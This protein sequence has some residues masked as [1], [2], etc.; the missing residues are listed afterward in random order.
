GGRPL[1]YAEIPRPLTECALRGLLLSW[2]LPNGPKEDFLSY[3][4]LGPVQNMSPPSRHARA[5]V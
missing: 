5:R 3:W 4:A 1:R 2:A